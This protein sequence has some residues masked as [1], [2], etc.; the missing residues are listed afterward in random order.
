MLS[1]ARQMHCICRGWLN[2]KPF[3]TI[4]VRYVTCLHR[5]L[6]LEKALQ[7][8]RVDAAFWIMDANKWYKKLAIITQKRNICLFYVK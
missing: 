5:H 2:E 4:P 3:D 7:P 8:Q 6:A 1:I